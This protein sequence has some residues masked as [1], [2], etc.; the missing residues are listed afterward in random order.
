[1]KCVTHV[2]LIGRRANWNDHRITRR[3]SAASGFLREQAGFGR[4]LGVFARSPANFS[5]I[6]KPV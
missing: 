6:D 3:S 2:T 1:M 4:F 5:D